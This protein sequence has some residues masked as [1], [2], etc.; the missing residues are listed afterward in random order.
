MLPSSAAFPGVWTPTNQRNVSHISRFDS[1]NETSIYGSRCFGSR[2]LRLGTIS[3]R[4]YLCV[5][6]RV[7]TVGA[8]SSSSS[9]AKTTEEAA[10]AAAAD[11]DTDLE[12]LLE[13][14]LLSLMSSAYWSSCKQL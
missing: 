14:S 8:F 13:G 6:V 10:A 2:G 7:C 4:A 12:A 5:E 11:G 9:A 1:R 3:L